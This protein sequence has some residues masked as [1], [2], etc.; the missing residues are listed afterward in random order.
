MNTITWSSQGIHVDGSVCVDVK[1]GPEGVVLGQLH[2]E[3]NTFASDLHLTPE[4][5]DAIAY[6]LLEGARIAREGN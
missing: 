2:G 3:H 6:A 5:A 4:H 1:A